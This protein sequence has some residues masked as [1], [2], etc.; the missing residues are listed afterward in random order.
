IF[1]LDR[2][3]LDQNKGQPIPVADNLWIQELDIGSELSADWGEIHQYITKVLNAT[4]IEEI[5]AEE[6]AILPGM[7]EISLLLKINRYVREKAFDTIILDSAPTGEAVRFISLPTALEWYMKKFFNLERRLMKVARPIVQKMTDVPLPDDRYFESIKTL[8]ERLKGV[9]EVLTDPAVTT[10]RLVTNPEKIVLKETQRAFMYFTLYRMHIDAVVINRVLPDKVKDKYFA[11]WQKSQKK[12]I[13]LAE[14]YFSPLPLF[15]V[16]LF[17]G[18]VLGAESLDTLG[19]AIYKGQNP[20]AVLHSQ[21]A[22]ELKKEDGQYRLSM[23][24]AFADKPDI[25]VSRNS[26]ELIV[27]LGSFRRHILLPSHVAASKNARA[28]FAGDTLTVYFS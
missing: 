26:T 9:D 2:G 14:R 25:A 22:Y 16:D 27:R 6:L 7:E 15:L 3:L 4:G 1:D 12:Y 19:K 24:L 20:L 10:V 23:R 5:L 28:K 11:S 17:P 18:E 8:F 21:R 13:A